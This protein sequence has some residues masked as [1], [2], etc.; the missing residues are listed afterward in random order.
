M[1]PKAK[2]RAGGSHQLYG[3]QCNRSW[4]HQFLVG[5]TLNTANDRMKIVRKFQ[6]LLSPINSQHSLGIFVLFD[7][8]HEKVGHILVENA[9]P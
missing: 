9:V 7:H 8:I 2:S 5:H 1:R 4:F 3:I 6:N